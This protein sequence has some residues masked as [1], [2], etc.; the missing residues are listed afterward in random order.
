M[1][2]VKEDD[3]QIDDQ[4]ADGRDQ[5][6]Q[7]QFGRAVFRGGA[8]VFAH[9]EMAM[10]VFLHDDVV[11]EQGADHESQA[12]QRHDVHAL[13]GQIERDERGG[14]REGNGQADDQ[15]RFDAAQETER[16]SSR[17]VRRPVALLSARLAMA[18][19]I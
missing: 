5:N 13:T 7:R 18:C 4:D 8:P 15:R 10:Q 9:F 16:S 3:R 11:I 14:Q 2:P 19:R 6:R 17:P 12:A 1:M